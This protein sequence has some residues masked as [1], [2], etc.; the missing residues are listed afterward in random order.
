[1]PILQLAVSVNGIPIK[2]SPLLEN[3]LI[4]KR[5][6]DEEGATYAVCFRMERV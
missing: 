4:L 3:N 1:M 6:L 5:N 2:S